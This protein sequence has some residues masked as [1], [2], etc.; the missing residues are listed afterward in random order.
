[1]QA[2]TGVTADE[3]ARAVTLIETELI[4][5]AA[6][7]GRSRRQAVA[8][9]DVLR[10]SRARERAGGALPRRSRPSRSTRSRASGSAQD[11]RASLLYVPRETVELSATTELAEAGAQ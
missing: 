5:V 6:V 8:V 10:R 4:V 1:M 7:G 11:N 9:R 3:V 2:E